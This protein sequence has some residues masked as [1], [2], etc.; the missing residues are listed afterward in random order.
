MTTENLDLPEAGL[1]AVLQSI[2][3]EVSLQILFSQEKE[4]IFE[5][6]NHE[7]RR[8]NVFGKIL[9]FIKKLVKVVSFKIS[10]KWFLLKSK[11]LQYIFNTRHNSV[12]S[13]SFFDVLKI[14]NHS[15]LLDA[16][17]A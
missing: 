7:L 16:E 12:A 10:I 15:G 4:L 3:C 17:L 9:L 2:V 5:Y 6:L 1:D 14:M 8:Q 13:D 11:I